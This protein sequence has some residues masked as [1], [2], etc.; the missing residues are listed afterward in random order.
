MSV[1]HLN[2]MI[3]NMLEFSKLRANKIELNLAS[4]N[5]LKMT[6]KIIKMHYFKAKDNGNRLI[7]TVST[8]FPK[9]VVAD[10]QRLKQIIINLLSNAIKFTSNGS[11]TIKIGWLSEPLN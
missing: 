8:N 4:V 11:V 6:K 7:L 9:K 3:N 1:D 2:T 5:L 10:E